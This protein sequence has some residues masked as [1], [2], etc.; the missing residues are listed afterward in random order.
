MTARSLRRW[1]QPQGIRA[2]LVLLASGSLLLAVLLVFVFSVFQ[3]Q[4]LIRNEWTQS[5]SAQARLVATN[6]QAAVA[7]VD[8]I[9]AFRLLGAVQSNPQVLRA[10]LIMN[11]QVFAEYVN[12][13]TSVALDTIGPEIEDAHVANGLM[14]VWAA[15]PGTPAMVELTAS[16]EVMQ[17][18]LVRTALESALILLAALGVSLWL[19]ARLVRK[20]NFAASAPTSSIT[21]RRVMNSPARFDISTF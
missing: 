16:L 20:M 13:Q 10:R 6:S 1:L 5:L 2:K 19:S 17:A 4:R 12:P 3:Q 14:T 9:E 15:V 7:F 18:A 11:H 8:R 21:S